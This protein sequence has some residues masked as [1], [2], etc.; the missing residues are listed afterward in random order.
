MNLPSVRIEHSAL[1]HMLLAAVEVYNRECLGDLYG[2]M[3]TAR[4]NQY[5][6]Q[7][8][9]PLQA[10]H[11]RTSTKAFQSK[12]SFDRLH[13]FRNDSGLGRKLIGDFHSHPFIRKRPHPIGLSD[14]DIASMKSDLTAQEKLSQQNGDVLRS[15]D[16]Y[17]GLVV[18]ISPRGKN[19]LP[20][21]VLAQGTR[22]RGTLGRYRFHISVYRLIRE[23]DEEP[24]AVALSLMFPSTLLRSL[25]RRIGKA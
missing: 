21:R 13:R 3:P 7:S 4:K 12:R 17:L 22:L 18:S 16:W 19:I 10:V 25:N 14:I 15:R 24:K 1:L 8:A 23:T 5:V 9:V 6:I 11:R 20:W 2:E